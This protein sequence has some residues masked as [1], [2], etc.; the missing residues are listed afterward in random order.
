MQNN[1]IINEV[2]TPTINIDKLARISSII[3]SSNTCS[4]VAPKTTG[5]DKKNENLVIEYRGLLDEEDSEEYP[6]Y[7]YYDVTIFN[8]ILKEKFKD[9]NIKGVIIDME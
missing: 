6:G 9:K 4:N 8:S 1:P 5:A 3:P 7:H 2:N